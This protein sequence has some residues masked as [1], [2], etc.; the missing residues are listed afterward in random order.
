MAGYSSTAIAPFVRSAT[1]EEALWE[2]F[3]VAEVVAGGVR[4]VLNVEASYESIEPS[5][6]ATA[7][8][9]KVG[10]PR[11]G[12]RQGDDGRGEHSLTH[13]SIHVDVESGRRPRGVKLA[14][15]TRVVVNFFQAVTSGFHADLPC[16][17]QSAQNWFTRVG[18]ADTWH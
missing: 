6:L 16:S 15:T 7:R 8:D 1:D 11:L 2:Q 18:H 17:V 13:Q 4:V 5:D 3:L 12:G 14:E 9:A 10:Q